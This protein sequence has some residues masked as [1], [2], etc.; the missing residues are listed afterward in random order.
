MR[1]AEAQ[2]T[3]KTRFG[4]SDHW[5]ILK[6]SGVQLLF[7]MK[8]MVSYGRAGDLF[9]AA[10]AE[11]VV[12]DT[13]DIDGDDLEDEDEEKLSEDEDKPTVAAAPPGA[14]NS[15]D[16]APPGAAALLAAAAAGPSGGGGGGGDVTVDVDSMPV[17]NTP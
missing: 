7:D 8:K 6:V 15:P 10:P 16:A 3:L 5:Q 13:Q 12:A 2:E 11:D 14:A 9:A 17:I 1:W 4:G